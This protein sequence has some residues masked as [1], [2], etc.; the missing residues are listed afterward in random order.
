MI[1]LIIDLSVSVDW[2]R[3][4]PWLALGGVT[5]AGLSI[6]SGSLSELLVIVCR[7]DIAFGAPSTLRLCVYQ[8]FS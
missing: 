1:Q 8:V 2:L 4:K 3:S 7:K 5:C 6:V